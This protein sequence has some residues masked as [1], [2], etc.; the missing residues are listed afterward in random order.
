MP[1]TQLTVRGFGAE[2]ER[3]LKQTARAKGISLNRAALELMQRGAGIAL[4]EPQSHTIG[5]G[6]DAFIG[7]WSEAEEEEVLE[8]IRVF[9]VVDEELWE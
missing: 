6:L 5:D 4:E 8:A 7:S 3:R 9:E 1:M 2:L